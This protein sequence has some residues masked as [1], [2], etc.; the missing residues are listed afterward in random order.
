[1]HLDVVFVMLFAVATAV[2]LLARWA[3]VPYTVALVVAGLLLGATE[4]FEAVPLTKELL[5]ALILPG[6]LFDAAFHLELR[7]FREN[8][9]LINALAV[10]GIAATVGLTAVILVPVAGALDFEQGFTLVHGLVFAAIIGATDP[11]AVVGLFKSLG[12]PQRLRVIVEGESLLNDGTSI[13]TFT[14]ILAFATGQATSTGGAVLDFVKV[15]G[16]GIVVGA[17]IGFVV[18]TVIQRVDDAMI[19]ITLTTIA[20]YGSFVAAEHFEFSGVI[21]TVTAGMLCGNYAVRTGMTPTTRVA[22]ESFWEY[23]AFALNSI[24]FLLIGFEVRISAL[25]EAWQAIVVAY[26]AVLA[27][28]AVIVFGV[29]LLVRPTRGRIPWSWAGVLVWAG[30]RGALSMVLV[31]GLGPDFPHRDFLVTITFGV[32][33]LSIL[34]QGVT[35]APILRWLGLV[36]REA[37]IETYERER[38]ASLSARAALREIHQLAAEGS[39]HG[40]AIETLRGEYEERLAAADEALAELRAEAA[41]LGDEELR[42]ARR[43]L[44][45]VEKARVLDAERSGVIGTAAREELVESIDMR[46]VALEEEVDDATREAVAT[47]SEPEAGPSPPPAGPGDAP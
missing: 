35:M 29:T 42:T 6:L 11:I 22:V 39:L 38:G 21:A 40:E 37:A 45:L 20:A 13:V 31:L 16:M 9:L 1:M 30:L 17:A 27:A 8:A 25:L 12:A 24:V 18:T 28:R 14:L 19:E 3:R 23:I 47:R 7:R 41:A 46:L 2:A 10:P 32:V 44:L 15:V 34:V 4:A 43:R 26:V 33:L 5:Y 36:R